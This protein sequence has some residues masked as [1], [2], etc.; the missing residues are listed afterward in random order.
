MSKEDELDI[1]EKKMWSSKQLWSAL[2]GVAFVVFTIT[3]I[4]AQFLG[5][6]KDIVFLEE[7]HAIEMTT[8]T[9]RQDK[10]NARWVKEMEELENELEQQAEEIMLLKLD[11][12]E[13]APGQ[14]RIHR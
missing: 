14:K 13:P 1:I 5:M 7:S 6:A 10:Q 2:L 4:Y 12:H 9:N 3:M 11:A 8:L